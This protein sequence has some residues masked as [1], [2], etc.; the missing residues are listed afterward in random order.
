MRLFSWLLCA[1][2]AFFLNFV[3][4][5]WALAQGDVKLPKPIFS[6]KV[7][8]E[9]ALL[10]V[11]TVRNFGQ[12]PLTLPQVSQ[13]LWAANGNLPTDAVT[14]ATSKAIQSAGGLYPLEVFLVSGT[15]TVSG[16]PAGVYRYNPQTNALVT[17]APGDQRSAV[18]QAALGQ[19]WLARAPI[20]V[21]IAAEFSRT[22]SKYGER[23]IRYVAIEAGSSDQN[24]AL[25]A[26]S[27]GL[28][29]GTVGAFQDPAVA[30]CLKLPPGISPLLIIAVGG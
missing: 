17:I 15:D 28:R 2:C 23:G 7:S 6:G 8:V 11:R 22:T 26:A 16:I 29:V 18:G 10:K 12:K 14:G 30:Q 1:A 9:E 20:L 24:V 25:Q 21:I 5:P 19:M 3:G 4:A 27:L 13:I